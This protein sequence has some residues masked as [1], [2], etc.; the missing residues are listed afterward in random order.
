[1]GHS[2][3]ASLFYCREKITREESEM[4]NEEDEKTDEINAKTQRNGV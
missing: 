4:C 2:P 3:S 1:M